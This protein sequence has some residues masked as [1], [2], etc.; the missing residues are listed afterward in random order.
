MKKRNGADQTCAIFL[1]EIGLEKGFYTASTFAI[2]GV[3]KQSE[4]ALLHV[5]VDGIVGRCIPRA[6]WMGYD[7]LIAELLFQYPES[8]RIQKGGEAKDLQ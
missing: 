1:P 5:R 4:A 3:Q 2:T 7:P 6:H 8:G